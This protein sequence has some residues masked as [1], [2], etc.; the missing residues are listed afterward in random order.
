M[1]EDFE[2][3]LEES[4]RST[5][6]QRML[7]EKAAAGEEKRMSVGE[8]VKDY[9]G[10][11]Q[12]IDLHGHTGA[13]AMYELEHFISRSIEQ[14]LRTVRVITGKGLH[15]R[16]MRSVLP[17]LTER[18]LSQLKRSRKVLA[19]RKERTGGSYV[20]YLIS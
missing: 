13:E 11:Q 19:Y 16:H 1:S 3:L 12:E 4:L 5:E 2:R 7:R 18:K 6:S 17:E 10:P 20:V 14:H 9:P 15:S 8:L